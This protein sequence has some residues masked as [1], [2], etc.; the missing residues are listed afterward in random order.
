MN[1]ILKKQ[2]KKY[3]PDK[4][5]KDKELNLFLEAVN[6]SYN[7]FE[8]QFF[9]L[10]KSTTTSS[11]RLNNS[12]K[13]LQIKTNSQKEIILQLNNIINALKQFET[14]EINNFKLENNSKIV[15]FIINQAN[16]IIKINKQKDKLVSN[17]EYQNEELN[18]YAHM[19]SHDLKTPLQN[20]D[21]L[22]SWIDEDYSGKF[23]NDGKK[24]IKRIKE[25]VEKIHTVI[26]DTL[27]YSTINKNKKRSHD[28]DLNI[29]LKNIIEEVDVN[30]KILISR[31]L[32]IIKG[33]KYRLKLLF[34]NLI[35][36]AIKFNNKEYASIKIDFE[37]QN[38]FWMFSL[39]DNGHGIEKQYFKKI[40]IAFQKLENNSIAT[41]IGLSMVKKIIKA[42]EG[43]IWLNSEPNV[44]TTFY[45]TLKK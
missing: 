4:F 20:I 31:K 45:F 43:E 28:I 6:N 35:E 26:Q 36:N 16:E 34:Y 3:I 15:D 1:P 38:N 18:D 23:D 40:F 17:L 13:N 24:N 29:T 30:H 37:E 25:N 39:E 19:I 42:Y 10:L 5:Q 12:F 44:G 32:P 14:E 21:A 33:D 8:E 9:I 27:E 11:E 22:I 7:D 41:G 2:V